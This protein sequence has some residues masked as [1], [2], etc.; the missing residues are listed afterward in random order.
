MLNGS[1]FSRTLLATIGLILAGCRP[2]PA[3]TAQLPPV[4][5]D[6]KAPLE[7]RVTDLFGRLTQDEKLSLLT[8]RGFSTNPIPR[9]AIPPMNM[10]DAGQGVRGG[11]DGTT[12]PATLFPSGVAM[13][14]TWNPELVGQI[15]KA[16]GEEALNKG[17][18]VQVLL[19]PAVNIHRSPLGGRNGEYFSEDPY[20][21]SR[22]AVG[23][24]DGMQSTGCAACV[25]HFAANN[26]E[27]DRGYV[28][29]IVDERTLREIY[30][31]AFEAT[32]KEAHVWTLMS[33][34]NQVNNYHA[35][36]NRHLLTEILKQDWGWDG[37]VMSDWGAVHDTA[38]VVNAGND[39]EMPGGGYLT[40]S[41]VAAALAAGQVTQ[42]QIDDNVKRILRAIIRCGLLNG[43]PHVPNPAMI[44]SPAHQKLT[45]EAAAQAIVLLKNEGGLL[46]L[47]AAKLHS[48]AIIGTA[49]QQMQYG[50]AGSPGLTPFYH[51]SPFAGITARAGAGI[52]IN[53]AAGE[54]GGAIIPSTSLTTPDGSPGLK[55][56]YFSNRNLTGQPVLTRADPSIDF[57]WPG[58]PVPGIGHTEFSVRWTGKLIPPD[59][60]TYHLFMAADDG[61]RV[62]IDGK[63]VI[64]HWVESPGDPVGAAVDLVK[65]QSYNLR[66][67]Y[68]QAAG[69]A[70][71]HLHWVAPAK[72]V[73]SDAVAA[74]ANS[75][76]AI[77]VVST[78]GDEGE[79]HDRKSMDLPGDQDALI[80]A[81]AAANPRTIVVLNNGTPVTMTG[82]ID[83]VPAL[84]EAWFPGQEGGHALA[85]ILFG[86]VDPSGRLPD[87]LG[88]KREDYPDFGNFPG[89]DGTVKY[90]EGIY[91]GYRHFD[92]AG[93]TPLFPF[94]FGLSYTT[95]KYANARLS[96][97]SLTPDGTVTV[98]V[99][100]TNTGRRA[101]AEVVQ[102]YVHDPAPK[103]DKAVREL[104]GFAKVDLE[105]GQTKTVQMTLS[106]RSLAYCD[107][108][109]KEWK[110]DEGTYELQIGASSRDIRLT[111]PLVL[112]G[113][114]VEGIANCTG[115]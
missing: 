99:D 49:A 53:Y 95:F 31:P 8:G 71:A 9:L 23:Y 81:V 82:W 5:Q 83:H 2:I 17:P 6:A 107:V 106:G 1:N 64:D 41:K 96:E 37:M 113:D 26:E 78:R 91:V 110:A 74:A 47:D 86:D 33:S 36:A 57:N 40:A 79:G 73:F 30:L 20:L 60:G 114:Y 94:G 90:A 87:T 10:A 34:Y 61:C 105:P 54:D 29:V 43:A 55:A 14:S 32:T 39:L 50:A 104:K 45:Y 63:A 19:G 97:P 7:A 4:Y 24:I 66:V 84:L 102:L 51:I 76:V 108:P 42:A 58:G 18:G 67:E 65:G 48:I 12:G 69:D 100:V 28:N 115:P 22:L 70:F 46:P 3:Q 103:I 85:A 112:A 35:T 62:F 16:I 80:N 15:G 56:E 52:T 109:H 89:K 59:T 25:K 88:A 111:V 98:S 101:G 27:A 11:G 93:I 21:A 38:G 68:F 75:N 92:K 72:S 77:V 44:N 13:A